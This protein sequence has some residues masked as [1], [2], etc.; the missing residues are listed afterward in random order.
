MPFGSIAVRQGAAQPPAN[1]VAAFVLALACMRA[2]AC[3]PSY[4]GTAL[5]TEGVSTVHEEGRNAV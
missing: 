5:P 3:S 2:V 1:H 4:A